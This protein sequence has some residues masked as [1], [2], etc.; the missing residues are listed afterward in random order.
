MC[1]AS[2]GDSVITAEFG[3]EVFYSEGEGNDS[4]QIIENPPNPLQYGNLSGNFSSIWQQGVM[5]VKVSF[6]IF[7]AITIPFPTFVFYAISVPNGIGDFLNVID[8][9]MFKR[10]VAFSGISDFHCNHLSFFTL[11]STFP[12]FSH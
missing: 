11:N 3:D 9:T 1:A 2:L 5:Y 6:D 8:V 12:M 10:N 7:L 4:V